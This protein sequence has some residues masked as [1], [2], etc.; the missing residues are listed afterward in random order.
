MLILPPRRIVGAPFA[1]GL[2][3]MWNKAKKFL[4]LDQTAVVLQGDTMGDAYILLGESQG[5]FSK[6]TSIRVRRALRKQ[7]TRSLGQ[8]ADW[9]VILT[10][11]K[12]AIEAQHRCVSEDSKRAVN[13]RSAK[14]Q[15]DTAIARLTN[16]EN[17]ASSDTDSQEE[18]FTETQ[19]ATTSSCWSTEDQQ[20]DIS[21]QNTSRKEAS[22]ET[23]GRQDE[24]DVTREGSNEDQIP[25]RDLLGS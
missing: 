2:L 12:E 23:E 14:K 8:W 20:N 7:K 22:I 19:E 18:S 24:D 6:T 17:N 4:R 25:A 13:F 15:I 11:T 1:S 16:E 21:S 10:Q 3:D 5:W 9:T